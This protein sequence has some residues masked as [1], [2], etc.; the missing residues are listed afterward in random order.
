MLAGEKERGTLETLLTSSMTRFEIV[1]AKHLAILSVAITITLIQTLN[2]LAYASFKLVPLPSNFIEALPPSTVFLLAILYLPVAALASSVLL[3][4]SGV[5]RSYKEAQLYFTPVFLLLLVPAL[6]PILPGL[7][8][9]SAIVLVPLSN[10]ALAVRDILVGSF[11]WPMPTSY[12]TRVCPVCAQERFEQF[13]TKGNLSLVKCVNCSMVYVNPVVSE[14]AT[15]TFYDQ[16]GLEYL[17]KEKV[18]SDY[19]DTRFTRELRLFRKHCPHGP[20]TWGKDAHEAVHNAVVVEFI[21]HL[22]YETEMIQ[23]RIQSIQPT[24][25]DRHFFRKHGPNAT[26]GQ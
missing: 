13:L 20:F 1:A 25:L 8:L 2:L 5:A 12:H 21:A 22:A 23:P 11:D 14:M 19:S 7:T 18:E 15:G 10:V 26:Y 17:S 9:R 24:L 16:T 6:S 4:T 3:F